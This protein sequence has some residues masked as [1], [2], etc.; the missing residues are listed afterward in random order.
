M[1]HARENFVAWLRT[2]HAMEEQAVTTLA[3]QARRIESYPDLKARICAHLEETRNHAEELK[4]LLERFSGGAP[5]LKDFT[6]KIAATAQGVGGMLT[7]DEVIKGMIASYAFEHTEIATYRV[8]I[9]AADELGDGDATALFER[10]LGEEVA[11]AEW[12]GENLDG[13][14]RVFL[15]RDERDLLAKR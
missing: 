7:S 10:I 1:T 14:T 8:L 5:T 12:L 13:I 9:A 2:A 3:A 4:L 15:M 11:M 6:A